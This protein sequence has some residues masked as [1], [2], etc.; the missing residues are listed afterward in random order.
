MD[1]AAD[2]TAMRRAITLCARDL[3]STSPNPVVGCVIT[4]AAGTVVG[5]LPPAR[6]RAHAE[7]HALRAAGERARGATAYV[8]LEPCD[9]TG[10][11]GPCSRRSW[12]PASAAS[13]TR[14]P[15]RTR[16]PAAAVTP[17]ARPGSGPSA[18]CSR[19]RPKRATPPG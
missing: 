17:C 10:R 1:T 2:T 11:T 4:D 9:H 6:R 12:P 14:S 7:V 19:T 15:T 5:G 13:S 16:G 18:G 3:G 8:T